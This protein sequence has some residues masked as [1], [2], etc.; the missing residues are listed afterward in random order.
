MK[1][2]LINSGEN[3]KKSTFFK[4]LLIIPILILSDKTV[5]SL[6][7]GDQILWAVFITI[8]NLDAKTWHTQKWPGTLLLGFIPII[9]ER[10]ENANNKDKDLKA[11]I[12]YMAL[13]TMLQL[14]YSSFSSIE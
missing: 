5:I 7:H 3:N 11:K 9:H 2:I 13:K 14:T 4:P 1:C 6:S 10:L 8:E 12:Y